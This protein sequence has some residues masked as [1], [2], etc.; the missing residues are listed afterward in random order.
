MFFLRAISCWIRHAGH[1]YGAWEE[2]MGPN[3]YHISYRV[4]RRCEW[5]QMPE[6][7]SEG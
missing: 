4:C 7:Y 3:G 5:A 6:R 1:D 2:R